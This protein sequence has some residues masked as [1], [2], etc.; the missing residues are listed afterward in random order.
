M[1]YYD[2]KTDLSR[3][4]I[5]DSRFDQCDLPNDTFGL[6]TLANTAIT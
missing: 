1:Q 5:F 2:N 4:A 3:S 6:T